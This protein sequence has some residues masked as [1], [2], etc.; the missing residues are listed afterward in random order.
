MASQPADFSISNVFSNTFGVIARNAPLFLGL[1]LI[2]VGVPQLLIGLVLAPETADPLALMS[3]P[4]AIFSSV[5]G[6][7]VFLFLSIVL[8]ASLIVASANDLAGKPVNFGECV[9]RAIAKL[10]PLI[11]LGIVVAIGV[12]IGFMFLIIPGIILYLM[13]MIAVPV[14]MVE[15]LGVFESLSR[16]S[17]LTKGSRWK[18]LGLIIVFIVF[19]M[20]IAIPIGVISLISESLSLVSSA[21]LSTVSAAVGAAG[22]AAVYIELRGSKEGTSSDQLASVF[23]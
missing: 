20:I 6:Y 2:I 14:M 4:G 5:I 3:S 12:S 21:L 15:N 7:I 13:W 23:A 1:S 18:L 19:S 11:G 17:A 8:Q 10:F 22:I 16:S 9:N